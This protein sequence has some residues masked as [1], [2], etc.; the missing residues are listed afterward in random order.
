MLI[1]FYVLFWQQ[2][3]FD[4]LLD[5]AL[6]TPKIINIITLISTGPVN[7]FG[8][9]LSVFQSNLIN[10]KHSYTHSCSVIRH[11]IHLGQI[12]FHV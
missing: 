10:H 5:P 8:H 12:V 6:S 3:A 4:K 2:I 1:K 7:I 9:L 11:L